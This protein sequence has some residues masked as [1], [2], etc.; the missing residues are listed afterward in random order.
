MQI[1]ILLGHGANKRLLAAESRLFHHMAVD[2]LLSHYMLTLIIVNTL[3]VLLNKSL[4][5]L[6]IAFIAIYSIN[7]SRSTFS[8]LILKYFF[9]RN[10]YNEMVLLYIFHKI[11]NILKQ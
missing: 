10:A 6:L 7:I 2:G 1:L 9:E 5:S 11:E 4:F 8:L 3:L